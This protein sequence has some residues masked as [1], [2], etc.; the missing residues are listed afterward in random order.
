MSQTPKQ[1]AL[2][3]R[4]LSFTESEQFDGYPHLSDTDNTLII[5]AAQEANS[6]DTAQFL[7]FALSEATSTK[8]EAANAK[9]YFDAYIDNVWVAN[10]SESGNPLFDVED[11]A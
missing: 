11:E 8:E 2:F 4:A 10:V 1:E 7:A 5:E 3:K 9:R 6:P